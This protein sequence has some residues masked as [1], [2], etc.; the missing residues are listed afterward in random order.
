MTDEADRVSGL[1]EALGDKDA[2]FRYHAAW[3]PGR[4]GPAA[5]ESVQTLVEGESKQM[6][7]LV[8]SYNQIEQPT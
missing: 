2:E 4:I 6:E 7:I 8:R 1:V 5:A 3:A